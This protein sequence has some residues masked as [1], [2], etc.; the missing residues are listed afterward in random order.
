MRKLWLAVVLG[1]ILGLGASVIP[2]SAGPVA[3]P[4]VLMSTLGAQRTSEVSPSATSPLELLLSGL[5]I[6]LV[7][8]I[9]VL[10][11]ARRRI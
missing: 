1:V 2:N 10:V 11:L 5:L 6:G 7:I 4:S 9:P 8:A 3:E